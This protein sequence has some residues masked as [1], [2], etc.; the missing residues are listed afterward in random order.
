MS[1]IEKD[2]D[3]IQTRHVAATITD[4]EI[5]AA[6]QKWIEAK[7]VNLSKAND[8]DHIHIPEEEEKSAA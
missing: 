3:G 1:L 5:C 6:V 2:A 4:P 8:A 7:G